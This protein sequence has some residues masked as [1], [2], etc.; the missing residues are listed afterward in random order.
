MSEAESFVVQAAVV[1]ILGLAFWRFI[2]WVQSA[3]PAPDPWGPE[4]E[5][6]L[7]NDE[8]SPACPHCSAPHAETDWFC[9]ECGASVGFYN[10]VMPYLYLFSLGEV[11]RTGTSGRFPVTWVTVTGYLL[12]PLALFLWCTMVLSFALMACVCLVCLIAYWIQFLLKV[13]GSLTKPPP[14]PPPP[15][16]PEV[17]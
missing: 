9:P 6:A 12:L 15:L 17:R 10:N 13:T 16:P 7:Q 11:L 14:L 1:V 8:L 3:T 2:L 4:L 5:E